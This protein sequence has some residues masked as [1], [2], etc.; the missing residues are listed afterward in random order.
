MRTIPR[1]AKNSALLIGASTLLL[2]TGCA[3]DDREYSPVPAGGD[4]AWYVPDEIPDWSVLEADD[5]S[6]G[7]LFDGCSVTLAHTEGQ[8]ARFDSEEEAAGYWT[9]MVAVQIGGN[10]AEATVTTIDPVE[11]S[12]DTGETVELTSMEVFDEAQNSGARVGVHWQ[13]DDELHYVFQCSE[14]Y[15]SWSDGEGELEAFFENIKV[16]LP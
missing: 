10:V 1:T 13:G 8:A 6:Q 5:D 4:Y 7:F 14:P 11:L 15:G 9:D 16:V 12:T 2:T 3:V